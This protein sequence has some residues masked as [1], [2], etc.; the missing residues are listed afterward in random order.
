[1]EPVT[2]NTLPDRELTST[3]LVT[4]VVVLAAVTMTFGAMI[5]VFVFRSEG[6]VDW[7]RLTVPS[8]LWVT[9]AIL[10]ASSFS[11]E[12][13]RRAVQA[14]EQGLAFRRFSVTF[15]L[16]VLFLVGQVIAWF[17]VLHS[18]ISLKSNSHSWFIF[19]FAALHGL[20]IVLGLIGVGLLAYRTHEPVSGRKYQARTRAVALG[21]SIF[22][23]YL[24]FL[25]L[26]LFA[27]L[28]FWKR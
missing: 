2:V 10:L 24:G 8:M 22:W 7:G 23:H 18:G 6:R 12:R 21:V 20:H 27:L 14:G 1:M 3:A 17:Q 4:S 9:T 28:L 11:I 19:L 13:S 15:G 16:G 5:A 25:W 26:V